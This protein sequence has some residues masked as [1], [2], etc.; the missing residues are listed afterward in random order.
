MSKTKRPPLK[1]SP[2]DQD[3]LTTLSR[4]RTE[5]KQRVER[6]G[7]LLAYAAGNK[8]AAIISLAGVSRY[9]VGLT[10]DKAALYGVRVALDDLPRAG[11]TP[12][13]TAEAKAWIVNLA[14]TKP[15]DLGYSY[16][17]WTTR[18]LAEHAQKHGV[19]AG[20]PSLAKLGR[21]TVSKILAKQELKP[22]K[23]K[24]YLERRDPDFEPKMA[25]VLYLYK[26]VE[27]WRDLKDTD[28]PYVAVLSYDEKPGI[29]AVEGVAP[30]LSPVPGKHPYVGRDYEYIRHGT[31]SLLAGID[32]L[33]GQVHGLTR[34]RHRSREF[35]EWL[36]LIDAEYPSGTKIRVLLDNHSAHISKETKGY[37]DTIP[38][39][40]EFT[41]TPKHGSWLN[42]VESFFGKMARTMLRGIRVKS[43]AEL[44]TRLERYLAEV[45]AAPVVFKWKAGLDKIRI[46]EG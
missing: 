11:R 40:F 34:E 13:I 26:E 39:R 8:I 10:L 45:N 19:A 21:G 2:S 6:A 28:R 30:D 35:I 33:S 17:L 32:L 27:M 29:Q 31:L 24:Y 9:Q 3:F 36:K 12:A 23:M 38:G 5:P 4:S 46:I 37:L 1:L 41:F 25:Q 18:L 44:K 43:K 42:L 7:V 14:C 22:Q 16:E 15:K 20:Q